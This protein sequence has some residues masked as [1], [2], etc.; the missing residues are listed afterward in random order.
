MKRYINCEKSILVWPHP[1]A[2]RTL[3]RELYTEGPFKKFKIIP[4]IIKNK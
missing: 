3:P 2:S 1:V 4:E